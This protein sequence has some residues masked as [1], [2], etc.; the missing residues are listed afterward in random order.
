MSDSQVHNLS[1]MA[2]C[3]W[4]RSSWLPGGLRRLDG[5]TGGTGSNPAAL[6]ARGN[7]T[8]LCDLRHTRLHGA[9]QPSLITLNEY[10]ERG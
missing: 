9:L 5:H 7:G 10:V 3:W 6:P 2:L 8:G 1:C 4:G